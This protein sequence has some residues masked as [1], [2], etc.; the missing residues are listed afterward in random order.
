ML[1]PITKSWRDLGIDIDEMDEVHEKWYIRSPGRKILSRGTIDGNYADWW[2]TRSVSFQ[3]NAVGPVR[4][5]LIRNKDIQFND[6]VD[7][8][9]G[10]LILLDE[11]DI[12]YYNSPKAI[13]EG[14]EYRPIYGRN[15][16]EIGK[17]LTIVDTCDD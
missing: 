10:K 4:A 11:L 7:H 17:I 13:S 15:R 9:T 1:L 8:K 3:N 16:Q 2:K 5:D 12:V 14:Y 6:I